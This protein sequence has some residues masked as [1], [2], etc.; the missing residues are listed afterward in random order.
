MERFQDAMAND[1]TNVDAIFG[2]AE[3]QQLLKKM[4]TQGSAIT[5]FISILCPTVPKA[6]Q[7]M[8]ASEDAPGRKIDPLAAP[9]S[10]LRPKL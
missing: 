3:A 9:P 7:A 1:P 8:K 4:R 10:V 2:L 5:S 6:K